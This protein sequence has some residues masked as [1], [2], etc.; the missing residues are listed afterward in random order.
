MVCLQPWLSHPAFQFRAGWF[1]RLRTQ[2]CHRG[3][4]FAAIVPDCVFILSS[5][6]GMPI[7]SSLLFSSRSLLL[8]PR[9]TML[10][11]ALLL[12]LV[13]KPA[14][15]QLPLL[16]LPLLQ[17][18]P[19]VVVDHVFPPSWTRLECVAA[20]TCVPVCVEVSVIMS[21]ML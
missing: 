14:L 9:H 10:L 7:L 2:A 8:L 12:L 11:E 21:K 6:L 1:I 4:A 17:L 18:S 13:L 15:S 3:I 5:P 16:L 20:V 19:P